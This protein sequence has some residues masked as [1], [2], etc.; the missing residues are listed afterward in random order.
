MTLRQ[1]I[2]SMMGHVDHGK[3]TLLDRIAG[4]ARAAREAGGITQHIGALEVPL[5]TV[6][7]ICRGLIRADQFTVPGL[8]FIDTPGHRSFVNM[9]RRGGAL[10][11]IAI[12]VVDMNEGVMPQTREVLQIL[13]HETTP[14]L[15]A[16]NKVDLVPGFRSP[17]TG[18][19]LASHLRT[20]PESVQRDVDAK[21]YALSES[22]HSLGF[23]AERY[24]RIQDYRRNVAIVP[25]SGKTGA[26]LPDLLAVL[27]GLAQRF[28]EKE[29]TLSPDGGE[30]TILEVSEARGIGAVANVVVYQGFLKVGDPILVTGWETPFATHIRGIYRPRT[31]PSSRGTPAQTVDPI[32]E[33]RAASGVQ[34]SAPGIEKALPGGL[35]RAVR[36]AAEVERARQELERESNPILAVVENGVWLKADTLGALEAM[37]FECQEGG[38]PIKGA[39][40]GA[41]TRRDVMLMRTVRDPT[42][43]A[44]LAFNVPVLPEAQ[45]AIE[46][47]DV[48]VIPGEVMYRILEEFRTWQERRRAELEQEKRRS[49]AYPAKFQVLPGFVFRA[50]KP[51][52]VGVRV[53]AGTLR[54]P[55]R[56][57]K[58]DGSDGGTLRS[59]QAEGKTIKEATEGQEVAAAIDGLVV[60]RS[61]KPGDVL[62]VSLTEDAAR[63]LR[64]ENLTPA[65]RSV[66]EEVIRIRRQTQPFWGT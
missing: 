56:L 33:V 26:G 35:L 31:N 34:I 37:V 63:T 65:E 43:R 58:P 28:L 59:L 1:P 6:E 15:V 24:D 30:A 60:G 5:R 3:T 40:V 29:L 21:V 53:L 46:G 13:R 48:Q 17:P 39:S 49:I 7:A 20:L 44:I 25:V 62:L 45:K 4:S 8:L 50:S 22:L 11:D 32:P 9:R 52:I 41:V 38:I 12:V 14:F 61:V 55:C 42:C 57:I 36:E 2:I 51:A 19:S 64:G 66:L 23:S 54:P 27:V 18:Q 10:A 16:A 47:G